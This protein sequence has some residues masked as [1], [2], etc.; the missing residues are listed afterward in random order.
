VATSPSVPA[1]TPAAAR[2]TIAG[3]M[4]ASSRTCASGWPRV[5]AREIGVQVRDADVTLEGRVSDR[6]ARRLVEDIASS[7]PGVRDVFNR[8]RV[9][10]RRPA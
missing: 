3:P 6:R 8:I 4:S 7:V 1:P 9:A 2:A 10:E 5:D